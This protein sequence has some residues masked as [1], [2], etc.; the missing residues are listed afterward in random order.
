MAFAFPALLLV[1]GAVASR[2]SIRLL[3]QQRR[4]Q[5]Q[6]Q[7]FKAVATVAFWL[8]LVGWALLA[9][10]A[11]RQTGGTLT[12]GL[13]FA[14]SAVAAVLAGRHDR[15]DRIEENALRAANGLPPRRYLTPVWRIAVLWLGIYVIG[16]LVVLF[17]LSMD[18]P[19]RNASGALPSRW[20]LVVATATVGLGLSHCALQRNRIK[21]EDQLA[22]EAERRAAKP[23]KGKRKTKPRP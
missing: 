20:P 2:R 14:P 17:V 18:P 4:D 22:A 11:P 10:V 23:S 1:I 19:A 13:A 3:L 21:L 15:A 7:W 12:L 9:A 16:E 6:A 5:A 8:G